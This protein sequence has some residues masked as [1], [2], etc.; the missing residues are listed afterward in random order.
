MITIIGGGNI[1]DIS[2]N[3]I[4]ILSK[5]TAIMEKSKLFCVID[6]PGLTYL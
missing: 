6:H 5:Y 1:I 3:A 4:I 2:G